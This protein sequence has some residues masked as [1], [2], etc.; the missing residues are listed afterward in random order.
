MEIVYCSYNSIYV[1][2]LQ[3]QTETG[4]PIT[5]SS[6]QFSYQSPLLADLTDD[7]NLEIVSCTH[8]TVPHITIYN[9]QGQT[10]QGWPNFFPGWSYCPPTAV[11]M[12]NNGNWNIF[13]GCQGGPI[14]S[15]VLFGFE[16]S[17]QSLPNFPIVKAGGAE[18][19]ISVADVDHDGN[20]EVLVDDNLTDGTGAGFLHAFKLDGSGEASGFPL[21]PTGFT[22][23]NGAEMGDINNDGLL[24]VATISYN[25]QYAYINA[26]SLGVTYQPEKILF[27]TYHGNLARNGLSPQQVST[28][29][30]NSSVNNNQIKNFTLSIFPNPMNSMAIVQVQMSN[31][32]YV[33]LDL[34]DITGRK[35]RSVYEGELSGGEHRFRLQAN[36][37]SSGVYFFNLQIDGQYSRVAKMMLLK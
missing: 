35:V 12:D 27:G 34:F 36:D 24:D 4:W 20:F 8:G 32:A 6:S 19:F 17:G 2:N 9:Y 21:R 30:Y 22:Y 28:G 13:A 31:V 26:W 7:G 23:L 25:D 18:G 10:L 37:L 1:F 11:D 33:T 3:G 29:I 15:A 16:S 5:P 14:A